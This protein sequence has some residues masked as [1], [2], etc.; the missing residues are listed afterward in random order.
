MN[1]KLLTSEGY[2]RLQNELNDL[3]RKERPEITKIVSWAASLGDRSEN[4]DYIYNKKK[5]REIDRRI[6][7]L[8][9]LFE[10]AHK[11][12]YSPEQDGKAYFG[13]WVA[14]ENDEGETIEFRIVGDEEIYGRKD[15]ISLQSPMAKAC[16]GKSINDEV[17]VQTPLG[18]KIWYINS[19]RYQSG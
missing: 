11:V 5:L 6:R 12:E 18:R 7:Y 2:Q 9:K 19:I 1:R 13:A 3:V 17:I 15:Y 10:V 4:A 8:T 16:L 14:L